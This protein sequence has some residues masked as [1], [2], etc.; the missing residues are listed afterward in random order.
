MKL[1]PNHI[2]VVVCL[3]IAAVFVYAFWKERTPG[4]AAT[5]ERI[6]S[7]VLPKGLDAPI[8][9]AVSKP[10][11]PPT[12]SEDRFLNEV[13]AK[14]QDAAPT[15]KESDA[16]IPPITAD[17]SLLPTISVATTDLDMG[18]IANNAIATK[19]LQVTNTGK[20]ELQIQRVQTTCGC[21]TAEL[22][23]EKSAIAPGQSVA[24]KVHVDPKKVPGFES[25]KVLSIFSNDP[26]QPMLDV[27]VHA[28]IA[29]EFKA[30][31]PTLEFGEVEKGTVIA[32]TILLQQ[33]GDQPLEVTGVNPVGSSEGLELSF[34]KRPENEWAA[35]GRAE[36]VV[37]GKLSPTA[38]IGLLKASFQI[39]TKYERIPRYLC[40]ANARITAFYTLA[41]NMVSLGSLQTGQT[42]AMT[43]VVT[44]D[45]PFELKNLAVSSPDFQVSSAPGPDPNTT[46][47]KVEVLP[48]AKV[49]RKDERVRFLVKAGDKEYEETLRVSGM[50]TAPPAA[51]IPTVPATPRGSIQSR[52][53]STP[54]P[55]ATPPVAPPPAGQSPAQPPSVAKPS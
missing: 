17:Q 6:V 18:V 44:G 36:Y 8:P 48:T 47:V 27:K 40:Q 7:E 31:P 14:G 30:D 39:L 3:G 5:E 43:V 38:P 29:P 28:K 55:S 25:T 45:R 33:L 26:R 16:K 24:L 50:I 35:P 9:A 46:M 13:R 49:G 2:I 10:Q 37:T 54:S 52:L 53:P 41:P 34:E 22:P 51:K 4:K 1:R 11:S 12:T 23:E 15:A 42:K 19:E 20:T 32:K 21:T